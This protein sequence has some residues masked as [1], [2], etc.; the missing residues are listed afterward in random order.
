[1]NKSE[2]VFSIIIPVY[3]TEKYIE[4]C[5]NSVLDAMDTDCE[6]IIVNDG[7]TDDSEKIIKQFINNLPEKYKEN[8]LYTK[9]KN[10]GLADTKNVGIEMARGKFISVVDSDD[11]IDK[12]FYKIAREYINNYDVIIYDL[13]VVFE[14]N[15]IYNYTSRAYKE[16]KENFLEGLLDGAM[17]GSS[18]NKIIKKE[19]YNDFKFPV[20]K[21]Y[22]DVAVTPFILTNAKISSIC[23]IHFTIT[24]KERNR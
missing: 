12:N 18:C 20:G 2:F 16:D 4:K 22:E 1:M 15:P 11:Y 19:L 5:L 6:V 24:C 9:K 3:N 14:K 17:S 7:A 8:F 10:K 13:Y 23:H 21:Q